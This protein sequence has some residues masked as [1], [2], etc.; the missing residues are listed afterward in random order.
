M[1]EPRLSV[2]VAEDDPSCGRLFSRVLESAGFEVVWVQQGNAAADALLARRF[3]LVL[4][5]ILLPGASGIDLL[6]L[7]R[8][9]GLG[10]RV[11]LVTGLPTIET[12]A[13]A[14]E[15]GAAHYLQKPISVPR[16]LEAAVR[17]AR[18][19]RLAAERREALARLGVPDE[20]EADLGALSG[21]LDRALES[22]WI[23]FQPILDGQRGEV[24]GYEALLRSRR[25]T[26]ITPQAVLSVAE[27]LGRTVEV[28]RRV[29]ELVAARADAVPG[30]AQIFVNLHAADLGDPRLHD[31]RGPLGRHAARVIFE[32]TE[33]VALHQAADLARRAQELRELGYRL[34]I[35]DL[36]A[37]YASLSCLAEI[38]PE[39]VK[40]DISLVRGLDGSPL[41]QKL[42]ASI[43]TLCAQIGA[44][45]VAEG[46][47][48]ERERDCALS[49]GCELQQGFLFG[50]PDFEFARPSWAA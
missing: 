12:A 37:G 34:A 39:F 9:L 22:M 1:G 26:L 35:D 11:I 6:A 43:A 10:A 18:G 30:E 31:P 23:A 13:E 33:R 2:L 42:V 29:R 32:V 5:D 17:A 8:D 19:A 46:I 27:R 15:L 16:L 48:T 4:A 24:F 21:Q 44:R 40:V 41:K 45:A 50:R 7:V 36:G 3:D 20:V 14:V 25:S 47:E 49:L 38:E 28:G